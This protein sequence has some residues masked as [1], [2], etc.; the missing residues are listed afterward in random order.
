MVVAAMHACEI[1]TLFLSL[2]EKGV[3]EMPYKFPCDP[4]WIIK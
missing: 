4:N 3:I 2:A 1:D